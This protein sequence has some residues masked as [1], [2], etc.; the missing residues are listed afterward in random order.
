MQY[1]SHSSVRS[2]HPGLGLIDGIFASGGDA[3]AENRSHVVTPVL[4]RARQTLP[5]WAVLAVWL[6]VFV[7]IAGGGLH[8]LGFSRVLGTQHRP[9]YRRT[10]PVA[11]ERAAAFLRSN[12][13]R[14]PAASAA[15]LAPE[16]GNTVSIPSL[17]LQLPLVRA[18]SLSEE[19]LTAALKFGV[20]LFPTG[21]DPGAKGNAVVTA[22]STA[23]PWKGPFRFAFMHINK[24]QPGDSVAVSYGSRRYV[25]RVTGQR[26]V[27]P[28]ELPAISSNTAG[29]RLT[30]VT[31]W[32][33]WTTD[34]RL[35]VEADLVSTEA[36]LTLPAPGV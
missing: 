16:L 8:L 29:S 34:R 3:D 23:E 35:L 10:L 25:Y 28:R 18:E 2:W 22:H 21:A 30:L 33:L 32:P 11:G 12:L 13:Q 4:R 14:L 26:T 5:A 31:C 9:A 17:A 15:A 20:V 27:D 19:D 6:L 36:R 7:S 1:M 24:L